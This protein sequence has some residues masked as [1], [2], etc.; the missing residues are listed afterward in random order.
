MKQNT[1]MVVFAL[2]LAVAVVMSAFSFYIHL[3][4]GGEQQIN[5]KESVRSVMELSCWDDDSNKI[6][7]TGFVI[8]SDAL[9]LITNAHMVVRE[10]YGE[11]GSYSNIVAKLANSESSYR[12]ELERYDSETDVALLRFT[13]DVH[14]TPLKLRIERPPYGERIIVIGNAMGYG[15]SVKEGLVSVPE[16]NIVCDGITRN[17]VMISL[18]INH[19]DSG[20]PILNDR[21]EVIGMSSFRLKDDGR[22]VEGMS[23]GLSAKTIDVFIKTGGQSVAT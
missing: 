12:M 18:T 7:G 19:G 11:E 10:K 1:E 17:T 9:Y 16:I 14:F 5:V 15:L 4:E 22:T 6:S 8:E 23:Y 21:G 13:E 3:S 20:S 2:L